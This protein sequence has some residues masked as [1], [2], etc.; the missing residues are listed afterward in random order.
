M[1]GLFIILIVVMVSLVIYLSLETC[2]VY[3]RLNIPQYTVK[4]KFGEYCICNFYTN[5][6]FLNA[7]YCFFL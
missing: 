3:F 1:I 6:I 4:N 7:F 2:V 5:P